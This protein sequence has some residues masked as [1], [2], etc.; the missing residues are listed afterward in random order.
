MNKVS[1]QKTL[2]LDQKPS[3]NWHSELMF[4]DA[5]MQTSFLK[6]LVTP[7][8]PTSPY[9]FLNYLVEHGLFIHS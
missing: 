3:F 7:V 8:D 1:D 6:D 5:D 4:S 9:S 2:F